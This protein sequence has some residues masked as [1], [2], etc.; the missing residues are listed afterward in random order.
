LIELS[1]VQREREDR[2]IYIKKEIITITTCE[3]IK[4]KALSKSTKR[5]ILIRPEARGEIASALAEK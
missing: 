1:I 2:H 4:E 3:S 5:K